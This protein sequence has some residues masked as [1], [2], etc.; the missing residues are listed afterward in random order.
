M[1]AV[2]LILLYIHLLGMALVVGG[3]ATQVFAKTLRINPAMLYGIGVQLVTGILLSAPLGRDEDLN[4]AK[5]GVKLL[6]AVLLAIM[7][8]VPRNREVV[9]AGHFYAI[10]GMAAL[11]VAVAV[12]W[13]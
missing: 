10:G 9:A 2:R 3:F 1:E 5:V 12:F 13:T 8:W 4:Y 11:T 7:I 6:L